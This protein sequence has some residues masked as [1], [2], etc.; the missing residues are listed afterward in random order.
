MTVIT[1]CGS[2]ENIVLSTVVKFFV[3]FFLICTN[4]W[5]AALSSWLDCHK[6]TKLNFSGRNSNLEKN[7]FNIPTTGQCWHH[8][9]K[10]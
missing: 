2:D 3:V 9:Y 10:Y 1:V 7:K 8:C 6:N 4:S 5:T